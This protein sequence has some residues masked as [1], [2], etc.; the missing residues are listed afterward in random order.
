MRHWTILLLLLLFGCEAEISEELQKERIPPQVN[1]SNHFSLQLAD[2]LSIPLPKGIPNYL[3]LTDVLEE[4]KWY[5]YKF[6]PNKIAKVN[7]QEGTVDSIVLPKDFIDGNLL[8][9][10]RI[11]KDSVLLTHDLPAALILVAEKKNASYLYLPKIDFETNNTTFTSLSNSLP[12][13]ES[14]FL[15]D[16]SSL[17]YEADKK[18]VYLGL[19]PYDAYRNPGFEK[20]QRVAVFDLKKEEWKKTFASPEGMLKFRGK[21]SY[22]YMMSQKTVLVK[23]D[24]TFVNYTNDH[25]IY[26]YIGGEYAGKF[27]HISRQSK[28]LHL[29]LTP[30]EADDPEKIKYYTHAAPRYSS[31]HYHEKLR[32]YSRLYFDQQDPMDESGR[33]KARNLFRDVYVSFLDENFQH[34]G[35]FKFPNGSIPFRGAKALSD[36]FI[37]FDPRHPSNSQLDLKQVYK[38]KPIENLNQQEYAKISEASSL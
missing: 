9:I 30:T 23:G 7:L 15:L 21:G 19:Q 38:I 28:Q 26:Y 6:A 4:D 5:Y 11:G 16:H 32:L 10:C 25:C 2:S 20:S 27:P 29:P 24:T 12:A 36:G 17:H 31:F 22:S 37:V 18:Q 14:N 33:Y 3:G 8:S 1:F 13:D 34:V 35:E